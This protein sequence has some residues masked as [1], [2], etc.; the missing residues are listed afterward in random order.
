M[1]RADLESLGRRAVACGWQWM[2]GTL[3]D[4]GY[5]IR[6]PGATRPWCWP[7]FSDPATLGCLLALVRE[8]HGAT[9][10]CSPSVDGRWY[11][12]TGM[13][14]ITGGDDT[15]AAALVAALEVSRG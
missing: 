2:P 8:K 14:L 5:R 3:D 11:V 7:D 4:V 1:S 15:E 9:A 6:G 10:H 12:W 13:A